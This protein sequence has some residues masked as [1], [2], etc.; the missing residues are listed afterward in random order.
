MRVVG[1]LLIAAAAH[2]QP[3][4]A[5][6][7]KLLSGSPAARQ[8]FWGI[9]VVDLRTGAT[10]YAKNANH[11]FIP[12]SNTKLF[13]TA[14]A[15][16]RLGPDHRFR[17]AI[18]SPTRLDASGRVTELRF[19]GGGDPNLSGRALPYE[20]DG[21]K[22]HPLRFVSQFAQQLVEQ[23]LKFVDGD[24]I[25]DDSAYA[26]EPYPDAWALDDPIYD[27]GAPVSALFVNDG[28]FTMHVRPT[29]PGQP[30]SIDCV[31]MPDG[32]VIHNRAIT[33]TS[34]KLRYD[35]LPGTSELTVTGTVSEAQEEA[36]GMEDPALFA[37]S[38]LRQELSKRGVRISGEAR[39]E[40]APAPGVALLTHDSPGLVQNLTLLNKDSINLHAE[41]A[42]LE[43]A[44][45]RRG[46][47]SRE[48]AIDELKL[49]LKEI[50][51]ADRQYNF[52][53]GSGLSRQTLLTPLTITKLLMYMHRS[54]HR[55][56]WISTLPIGGED[57]TLAKR[58]SGARD[59][60]QVKAKT[61]SITHVNALSGY[62]GRYAFS[63]IVNNSNLPASPVRRVM[64]QI[65]LALAK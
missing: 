2:A 63:M 1:L 30:P 24:I 46:V 51:V 3:I 31:P 36:L 19:V 32:L 64:D 65:A 60:S 48:T 33:G 58:F 62:T 29:V 42:L 55:E 28:M 59:A 14:L 45:V 44:R 15:L 47:A 56:A 34:T 23:G 13:S 61:G 10:A 11:F 6:I 38:A 41:V 35:R 54:P 26:F 52:K 49:F 4:G 40:H 50:G 8:A 53:D 21:E 7:D 39:V 43:V 5:R 18:T 37:A 25:G 9:H 12:A 20:P 57:G 27:Y 22:A 16:A 17:T